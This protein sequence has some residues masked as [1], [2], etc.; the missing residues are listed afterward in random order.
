[1][2]CG[3]LVF[4]FP[5]FFIPSEKFLDYAVFKFV[6]SPPEEIQAYYENFFGAEN[7]G[8][9]LILI[10]NNR[11]KTTCRIFEVETF[12]F[13]PNK[14][15]NGLRINRNVSSSNMLHVIWL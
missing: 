14:I 3:L 12:R 2:Q 7:M 15:D 1:M 13:I 9:A 6:F 8:L 5:L 4:H 10:K 11:A